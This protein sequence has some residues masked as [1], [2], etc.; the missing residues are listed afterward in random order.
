M[1][2]CDFEY[3]GLYLSDFGFVICN[4][5]GGSGVETISVG[6]KISFNTT[7]KFGGKKYSLTGT[8]YDECIET[9][10]DI[11]KDPSIHDDLRITDTEYRDL[12]RWLNRRGFYKFTIVDNENT[13]MEPR[14]Y[15]ASF[16]IEK[17][18][19]DGVLY[20]LNLSMITDAQFGFGAERIIRLE[21]N[22]VSK[23]YTVID[24]SDEIGYIYPSI[25]LTC[26]TDGT[27]SITND[28]E[29]CVMEIK[30]CSAGE[31]ITIDGNA[32]TI[33][34]SIREYKICND[35]N[36]GFL[37]IGNTFNDRINRLTISQPCRLEIKYCPIIKD[38]PN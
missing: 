8:T 2:A 26:K 37:K 6:S 11:C 28:K 18:T 23:T 5:N 34:S 4:F 16:N 27:I 33:H 38:S 1:H 12:I 14:Y 19:V 7:S 13:E 21:V 15:N 24:T 30:G 9:S 17:H 22:D 36:Y 3:D 25:V 32:L 20:G 35:F 29:Y 10:F 31:V